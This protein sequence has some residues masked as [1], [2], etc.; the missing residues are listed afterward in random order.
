MKL[1]GEF[2]HNGGMLPPFYYGKAYHDLY[3]D[4]H[5]FYPIPT[6]IIR[7]LKEVK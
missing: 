6:E 1:T 3:K 4:I 7:S 2:L 5:V